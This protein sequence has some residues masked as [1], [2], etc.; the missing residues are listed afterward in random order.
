VGLTPTDVFSTLQVYVGSQYVNDF[1]YLV[2]TYQVRVQSDGAFRRTSQDIARLKARNASGEMVPIGAVAQLKSKTIP[3]RVPR[4]NLFPAA[5]VQGVATPGVATGTALQRMEDLAHQVLPRGI[6]F[7]WT[8]LAFQQQQRGT[9]TL[10]VFG[11]AALFVFLVLVAQY[12]SWKLPLAIVLIVP[13]C[14]LA[15]VTG[16]LA[17]GMPIDILAQ[18]GFVVL[19]GLA[20]KNAIL[21]VEFARQKEEEG[22][23]PGEAAVH[24]AHTR[25]RPILMTSLSFILGVAPLA[26][27]TGAGAE[28]RQSLGTAVLFGMMGVTCFGLVFTPAFYTFIRRLGRKEHGG[29]LFN[30]G[31][32]LVDP[33][34]R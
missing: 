6:A 25:L 32:T 21:I 33:A 14:L 15:S 16:L 12:E 31:S 18:I 8:D 34:S 23:A 7:E 2:R 19:V 28:M 29:D 13:M 20:A 30:V 10:R 9:P 3:Y 5:E 27:A 11:T 24:A 1:N 26:V 17:R 22:V 4:Y